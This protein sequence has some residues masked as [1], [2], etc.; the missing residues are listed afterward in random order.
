MKCFDRI[1]HH[2]IFSA[3]KYFGIGDRFIN[4]VKVFFT[5]IFV[6]TQNPGYVS[7]FIKKKTR[8]TNQGCQISPFLY[9]LIGEV[10]AQEIRNNPKI[11][12]IKLNE[13]GN[14]EVII[15]QFADDTGL[16]LE[17]SEECITAAVQ[18]RGDQRGRLHVNVKL[19]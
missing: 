14:D 18:T 8:G 3:M 9:N 2:A 1:E 10:L 13:F 12:G 7:D 15:T 16:F 5:D 4:N 19:N 17:Y 6:C 11:K